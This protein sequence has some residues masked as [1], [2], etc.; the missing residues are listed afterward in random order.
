MVVVCMGGPV[1]RE[2]ESER[3]TERGGG[4][5]ARL[6]VGLPSWLAYFR[7]YPWNSSNQPPT[8]SMAVVEK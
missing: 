6:Q 8:K 1:L 5:R 2:R 3:V 4:P 7:S